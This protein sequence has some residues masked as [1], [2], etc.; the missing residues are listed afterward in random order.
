MQQR[1]SSRL[2]RKGYACIKF[3]FQVKE[4]LK[5]ELMSREVTF[6]PFIKFNFLISGTVESKKFGL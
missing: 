3:R 4:K 6:G 1:R 2:L 5:V